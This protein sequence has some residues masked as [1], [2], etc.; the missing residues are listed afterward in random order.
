MLTPSTARKG[1]AALPNS[2]LRFWTSS[3]A[4]I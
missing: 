3:R 2:T 1:V 4:M